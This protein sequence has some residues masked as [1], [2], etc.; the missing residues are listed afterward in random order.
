MDLLVKGAVIYL[1]VLALMVV[2]LG[3]GQMKTSWG[4]EADLVGDKHL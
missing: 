2:P 1:G 3:L 4:A